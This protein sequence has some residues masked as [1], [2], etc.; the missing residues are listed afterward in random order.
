MKNEIPRSPQLMSRDDT[1]VLV[2][3]VQPKLHHLIPGHLRITFNI[4]RLIDGAKLYEMPVLGTEQYPKGL[5]GSEPELAERI[6]E[7]PS[8]TK[9]SCGE[10]Q[11]LFDDLAEQNRSKLLVV[12]IETHVC[13]QQTVFDLLSERF[14]VYVAVDA[15]GARHEIDHTTALRRMESAGATL[16]TT[17]AALFEWCENAK[18]EHFKAI[19]ALIQKTMPC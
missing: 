11:P 19:S 3:D 16:T 5:G 12:G 8:K 9:F 1:A 7:M 14:E 15:V 6:G 2:V 4:G 18:D 17:E 10:C 13:I